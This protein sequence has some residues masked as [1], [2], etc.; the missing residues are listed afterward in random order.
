M[1]R[2]DPCLKLIQNSKK[3]VTTSGTSDTIAGLTSVGSALL[4]GCRVMS[5]LANNRRSRGGTMADTEPEAT[6]QTFEC[7]VCDQEL[8]LKSIADIKKVTFYCPGCDDDT[9][10]AKRIS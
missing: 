4:L 8:N 7:M 10:W 6:L 1:G 9:A 2:Y 5:S 3:I